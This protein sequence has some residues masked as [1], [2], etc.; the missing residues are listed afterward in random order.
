MAGG[1]A[2]DVDICA[3]G[4]PARGLDCSDGGS[5]RYSMPALLDRERDAQVLFVHGRIVARWL[6]LPSV[7]V[8]G[9]ESVPV[10][11]KTNTLSGP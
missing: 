11:E 8:I 2:D 10:D 3:R 5:T 9:A 6:S 1:D 4:Q 7:L